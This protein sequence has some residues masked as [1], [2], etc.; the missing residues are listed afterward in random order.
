LATVAIATQTQA[1]SK[2]TLPQAVKS[3]FGKI[4]FNRNRIGNLPVQPGFL[5]PA[6]R[7]GAQPPPNVFVANNNTV[8]N[9]ALQQLTVH[10]RNNLVAFET[11]PEIAIHARQPQHNVGYVNKYPVYNK[12]LSMKEIQW[13]EVE[14]ELRTAARSKASIKGDPELASKI[15]TELIGQAGF[16][17]KDSIQMAHLLIKRD[18]D[19]H[20][21][22]HFTYMEKEEVI[23]GTTMLAITPQAHHTIGRNY[24]KN[25]LIKKEMY[26]THAFLS[27]GSPGRTAWPGFSGKR[28]FRGW[29]E[30]KFAKPAR[31]LPTLKT[32]VK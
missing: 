32:T 15:R 26:K 5:R 21:T 9:P 10:Q 4:K 28:L 11:K 14:H 17:N 1:L 12:N 30:N 16:P 27:V 29:L 6:A 25:K 18:L 7:I 2:K 13:K 24:I 23:F 22:S 31:P 3:A 8:G 20:D 19:N